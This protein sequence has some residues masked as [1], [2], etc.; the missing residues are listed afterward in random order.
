[1]CAWSASLAPGLVRSGSQAANLVANVALSA[2]H[3]VSHVQQARIKL[4]GAKNPNSALGTVAAV[5]FSGC[6]YAS[7]S[8]D[9]TGDQSGPRYPRTR[10]GS[11]QLTYSL[12]HSGMQWTGINEE[13]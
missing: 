12:A 4:K 9:V 1:M 7:R 10:Q 13:N 11:R 2:R 3:L 5:S 8:Y 6:I